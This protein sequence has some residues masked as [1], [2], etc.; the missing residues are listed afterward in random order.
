MGE[1]PSICASDLLR[2]SL[3]ER[4]TRFL[5]V[6]VIV[7]GA[8]TTAGQAILEGLQQPKRE[9]RAF[10]TDE[11]VGTT[12]KKRGFKVAIGDVSDESHVETASTRCFSAVLVAEAA[13]DARERS[14]ATTTDDVL[15]GWARAMASSEVTRVIWV[16]PGNYP[17]TL[18]T[19]VASVDPADPDLVEKVVTM[20][21]AR[22]I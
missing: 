10:V 7:I 16:S 22:S 9:V 4:A 8:D 5:H 6:P 11:N 13:A 15:D 14:F 17:A 18:T 12:L 1:T 2:K 20:D 21:D 19:E 3:T